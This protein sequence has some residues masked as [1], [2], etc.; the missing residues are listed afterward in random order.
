MIKCDPRAYAKCPDKERCDSLQ[1][2]C[3]CEGS[4]CDKFNDEVKGNRE[5]FEKIERFLEENS[6]V[7][8]VVQVVSIA[9]FVLF[10]IVAVVTA[11]L[12]LVHSLLWLVVT[13][14]CVAV[15]GVTGGIALWISENFY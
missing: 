3:F 4:E 13:V 9:F 7:C 10:V 5:M 12:T 15:C 11:I 2:A 14:F 1:D 6:L 8:K